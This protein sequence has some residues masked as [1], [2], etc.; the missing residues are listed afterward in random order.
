MK[1][2]G[3]MI[4]IG[5]LIAL[6]AIAQA[7]TEPDA[8][9]EPSAGAVTLTPRTADPYLV[10]VRY[11]G[12]EAVFNDAAC[13]GRYAPEPALHVTLPPVTTPADA[14][15]LRIFT[16]SDDDLTLAVIAPDGTRWCSDDADNTLEPGVTIPTPEAGRYAVFVGA[17]NA[18]A[19]RT[20]FLVVTRRPIG[21][22]AFAPDQLVQRTLLG[23]L[24]PAVTAFTAQAADAVTALDFTA[25]TPTLTLPAG[26]APRTL[27]VTGGGAVDLLAVTDLGAA[28][29]GFV[30]PLPTQAIT[31]STGANAL[32]FTVA[33]PEDAVLLVRDPN[34]VIACNDDAG[35][36]T[37]DPAVT[38]AAAP[39]GMYLVYVGSYAPGALID[40]TLTITSD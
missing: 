15:A 30:S 33:A 27:P 17:Y 34:G 2:F 3:W 28:C 6:P 20:A 22:A 40:G 4:A 12:D 7:Q 31:L 32:R 24:Q 18:D 11:G 37:R 38:F 39:A 1:V 36:E 5:L 19:P 8:A 16:F 23:A 14:A 13:A 26:F 10:S 9:A 29:S 21:P 25:P 35:P